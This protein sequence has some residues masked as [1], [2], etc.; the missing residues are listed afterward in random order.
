V[1]ST[2]LRGGAAAARAF[3][4]RFASLARYGHELEV[5]SRRL[6]AFLTAL[7]ASLTALGAV[8]TALAAVLTA[9][10]AVL[11]ALA[12]FD[13]IGRAP[14]LLGRAIGGRGEGP[15]QLLILYGAAAV[16]I[17]LVK[18]LIDDVVRSVEAGG[19]NRRLELG[20]LDGTC[21]IR[22]PLV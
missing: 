13:A 14:R 8:L 17:H 16:H 22:V 19:A 4:T 11:T 5:L 20:A 3:A 15:L 12:A 7:A 1:L 18:E 2:A 9:L 21:P 10:A 6:A